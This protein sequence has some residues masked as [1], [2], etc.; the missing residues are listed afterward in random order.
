MKKYFAFSDFYQ[1]MK[2]IAAFC[3]A[4]VLI[5]Q[6]QSAALPESEAVPIETV[7]SIFNCLNWTNVRIIKLKIA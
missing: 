5:A 3:F 1:A 6:T 7:V 2:M 4:L